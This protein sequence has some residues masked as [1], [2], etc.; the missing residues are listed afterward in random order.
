MTAITGAD[1][2]RHLRAGLTA[3]H[4]DPGAA[5]SAARAI[6]EA[7][8]SVR[9]RTFAEGTQEVDMITPAIET[10][11]PRAGI[12]A[13]ALGNE[14]FRRVIQTAQ[15]AQVVAMT[16]PPGGEIGAE[17]HP[18]TDQLFLIVGGSAEAQVGDVTVP[19]APGDVVFVEAGTR[20]NITNRGVEALRLI[21][22]YS[23]PAH[24]PG[25]VHLTKAEADLAEHE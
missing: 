3:S 5:A 12:R 11:E 15:H 18:G 4:R 6:G 8:L 24:Q 25:T 13:Q 16:L 10:A 9:R 22:V 1:D 14:A 17:V 19:A 21:T 20:H 7:G 2:V 23:P